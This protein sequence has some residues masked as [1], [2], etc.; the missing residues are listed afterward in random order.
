MK[1]LDKSECFGTAVSSEPTEAPPAADDD[2]DDGA[3]CIDVMI[4]DRRKN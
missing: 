2:Q 1:E 3:W 4:T